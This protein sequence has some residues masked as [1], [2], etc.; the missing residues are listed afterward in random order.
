MNLNLPPQ[1]EQSVIVLT[2]W[3][4]ASPVG[5]SVSQQV[6][7]AAGCRAEIIATV[8]LGRHPGLGAPGGG[9]VPTKLFGSVLEGVR[10]QGGHS[11]A[12]ALLCGYFA[13]AD[14]IERAAQ[15]IDAAKATNPSVQIIVDPILGDYNADGASALYV[16]EGVANAVRDVLVPRADLITP[17][18]FELEWLSGRPLENETDL[19]D[20]ARDLCNQVVI[21]SAHVDDESITV[22]GVEPHTAWRVA[23]SL[24]DPAPKGTGDVF[25]AELVAAYLADFSLMDA[26]RRATARVHHVLKHSN[27]AEPLE[28]NLHLGV[29][30]EDTPLPVAQRVG[31]KR[32]AWAVGLDGAP[33]GWAAVMVDMNGLEPTRT[34]VFES[35]QRV[36]DTGAQIIAVDMPIGFEDRPGPLGMR[37]CEHHARQLLGPRRSSIFPTPLRD[38]VYADDYDEALALNKTLGGKGISKQAFN[39]GPKLREIDGL[40]T[41]QLEGAVFE[42]HPET[43]FTVLNGAP[44]RHSKKTPEGR[45]ERLT[46][47]AKRGLNRDLFEPHFFKR[48]DCAP[49]DLVDA[50][51]C[52]LT[53]LRIADARAVCLPDDPPRDGKGLRMA[54][55]A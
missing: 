34:E 28:L 44:A 19:I 14:Q 32:P 53:A 39:L 21:T 15:F 22:L 9:P 5:G 36:L 29:L 3:V 45:E 4:A 46:L 40:M 12:N 17:N 27:Q 42:T 49:D 13:G 31:A 18:R 33:G 10:A 38:A 55:W 20:A 37:A 26:T 7:H 54:I 51:L 24:I 23:T 43:S 25:A 35:F 8:L 16:P 50:G 2:S 48:K 30:A 11:V 1:V 6:L 41:V 47:L 52:A